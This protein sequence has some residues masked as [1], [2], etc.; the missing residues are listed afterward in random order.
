MFNISTSIHAGDEMY[1]TAL[2]KITSSGLAKAVYLRQGADINATIQQLLNW[3]FGRKDTIKFL[4]FA[5]GYGRS[6]RFLVQDVP[7]SNVW[8]SDIYADAVTF[9]KET[10]K[11]NGFVSCHN[12]SSLYCDEKFDMIFVASLFTHLPQERFMNWLRR[13]FEMLAPRGVLV[14]SLHDEALAGGR[15]IPPPGI[16]FLEASEF[17][18]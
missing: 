14:F 15:E 17:E 18:R 11:V 13:L 10:F 2:A 1:L 3:R 4:D 6:T 12:P 7:P 16:L 8:V 5:S 9:Q